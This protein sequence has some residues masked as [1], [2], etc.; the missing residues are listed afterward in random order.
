M[1][2]TLLQ[3]S[4]ELTNRQTGIHKHFSTVWESVTKNIFLNKIDIPINW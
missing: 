4:Q 2:I 3:H 1:D